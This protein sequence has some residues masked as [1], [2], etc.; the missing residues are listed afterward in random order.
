MN[1]L[2]LVYVAVGGVTAPWWA[3]K[4]RH[5][6][7]ERFGK[8]VAV[9]NRAGLK[10]LLIHAVSVGE[11]NALRE[12]VPLLVRR[13][14]VILS[15][16]TDTGIKRARELFGNQ[17]DV[18]RYPLDASWAVKRF[19]DRTRPDGVALV[20]LEL[21]PNF[22]KACR[23]R[24]IPVCVI[25]GRLSDRSFAGYRKLRPFLKGVFGSLAF[26]SV[27]EEAYAERFCAMG[28]PADR[29][30]V[31]GSMKWDSAKIEDEVGGSETLAREMG[32]ARGAGAPPLIVAGSTGPG[33]EELLVKAVEDVE[34]ELGPV[35]LLCAPRKP[36]RFDEAAAAMPGCVRRSEG[37][38]GSGRRFVLD[39][40]GELRRAYALA[41]VVVVGRSFG[42]LFGSDPIEPIALGKATV[43]GP[44]V[45]DFAS[46]VGVF[47]RGGGIV[48]ATRETLGS[49]VV[50]LLKDEGRRRKVAEAGRECIKNEQGASGR[51]AEMVM[52]LLGVKAAAEK[53]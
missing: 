43:I 23:K 30:K 37:R 32:I 48:R 35:Q 18:V 16:G 5:G 28:V 53:D 27:Q 12:L 21:W 42:D 52:E 36:E 17:C 7:G 3:R 50:G 34:R 25:N 47:E 40:I 49:E 14:H 39:T 46:I 4:Q 26:A 24:G 13:V 41:D 38:A 6:W 19:L 15:V 20:E 9:G 2:D 31:T 1:L 10:R 29:V 33:E 22:I 45:K 44:A 51:H 8:I 11:V